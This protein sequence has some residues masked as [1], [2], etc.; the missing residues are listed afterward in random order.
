MPGSSC[1]FPFLGLKSAMSPRNSGFLLLESQQNFIL[2]QKIMS[3]CGFYKVSVLACVRFFLW[4]LN[5]I[6]SLTKLKKCSYANIF[7]RDPGSNK[8][9]SLMPR[10][11]DVRK[12]IF[13]P[14]PACIEGVL[15]ARYCTTREQEVIRTGEG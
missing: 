7:S 10:R 12:Q 1:I 8:T 3:L 15:C 5:R 11:L 4:F 9:W 13:F 14:P 2:I 6:Y